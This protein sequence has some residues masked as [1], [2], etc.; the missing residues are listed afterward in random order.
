M[1]KNGNL[2]LVQ[3]NDKL[4]G[5]F[6]SLNTEKMSKLKG[7]MAGGTNTANC[8]NRNACANTNSGGCHNTGSCSSATN[9][10]SCTNG[11]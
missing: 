9:S 2:D 7:G 6:M 11:R 8:N 10:G 1:K 4:Q 3:K 5:G